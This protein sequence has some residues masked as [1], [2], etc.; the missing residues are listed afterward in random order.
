MKPKS[1]KPHEL[2]DIHVGQLWNSKS[3]LPFD[4]YKLHWCT[5]TKGHDYDP[6]TIGASLRDTELTESPYEVSILATLMCVSLSV[7]SLIS[8]QT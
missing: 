3:A 2:L 7:T 4:F 8:A 5:S 6:K 1:Y